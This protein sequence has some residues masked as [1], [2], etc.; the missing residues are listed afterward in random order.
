MIPAISLLRSKLHLFSSERGMNGS[1]YVMK[2]SI[3]SIDSLITSTYPLS[4]HPG[5]YQTYKRPSSLV[6]TSRLAI[7]AP[8]P[9]CQAMPRPDVSD[10]TTAR[11]G[12]EIGVILK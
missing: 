9:S 11:V 10:N 3:L 8:L 5:R 1:I 7:R 12:D 2:G 6:Y 4:S